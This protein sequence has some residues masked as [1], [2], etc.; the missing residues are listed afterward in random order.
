M[1]LQNLAVVRQ[2]GIGT[3][4]LNVDIFIPEDARTFVKN[5]F[6][7]KGAKGGQSHPCASHIKVVI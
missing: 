2:F 6:A 5:V 3:E 4:N 7:I 1:V